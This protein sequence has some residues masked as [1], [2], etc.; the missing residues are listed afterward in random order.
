[1]IVVV[2]IAA[3]RV[4][5]PELDQRIGEPRARFILYTPMHN[6]PLTDRLS[7][8]CVVENEVVIER[9]ELVGTEHWSGHCGS[10]FCREE[11][12][13]VANAERWSCRRGSRQAGG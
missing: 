2:A 12:A 4:G 3:S 13:G 1:M 8:L 9:T 7:V 5:L 10:E 6:D 11:E